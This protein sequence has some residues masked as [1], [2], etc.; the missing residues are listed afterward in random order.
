MPSDGQQSAGGATN[1]AS[2]G[3]EEDQGHG[4]AQVAEKEDQVS[5]RSYQKV[6][7]E[8]KNFQSR[9]QNAE[10]ELEAIRLQQ[11]EAEESKLKEQNEYKVLYEKIKGEVAE[12]DE[13][14]NSLVDDIQRQRKIAAF[15]SALKGQVKPAYHNFINTDEIVVDPETG[16]IDEMSVTREVERF[17]TE[18]PELVL[19]PHDKRSTST[20]PQGE[21]NLKGKI[22][23][24]E[25]AKL[26]LAEMKKWRNDQV[27]DDR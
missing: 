11:Q 13:K 4:E 9:L 23:R 24:S 21:A 8:K 6:L 16:E 12:K 26:P 14:F 2:S 22:L 17:S 18:Y 27:V 10:A 1:N 19:R 7:T 15:S 20:F 25:W 3:S 5:Y